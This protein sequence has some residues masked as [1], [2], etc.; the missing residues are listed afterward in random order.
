ME[1]LP[2]LVE[3][4]GTGSASTG[5][6]LSLPWQSLHLSLLI[7]IIYATFRLLLACVVSFCTISLSFDFLLLLPSHQRIHPEAVAGAAEELSVSGSGDE[8]SK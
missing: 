6:S 2:L 1:K 3:V 8:Q 4:I 7:S 5:A